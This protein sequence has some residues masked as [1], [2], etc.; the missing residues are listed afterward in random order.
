[1]ACSR[2]KNTDQRRNVGFLRYWTIGNLP[3]FLLS[4]PMLYL[5]TISGLDILKRTPRADV[6]RAKTRIADSPITL[7]MDSGG[8]SQL[9]QTTDFHLLCLQR[10]A[11]PQ[12]LLTGLAFT[13]FHVQI[14]TRIASGYPLWYIWC[15]ELL[16]SS[17]ASLATGN[18]TTFFGKAVVRG[19]VMYGIV[20]GGLYATF[21]PPA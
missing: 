19:I 21:L 12:I 6:L 1:L 4:A 13:S 15:A 16:H 20:Q 14:I 7:Q 5:L 8:F 10:L 9:L 17:A 2:C 11:V 18:S 3:L